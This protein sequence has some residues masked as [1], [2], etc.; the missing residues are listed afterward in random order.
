MADCIRKNKYQFIGICYIFF[1]GY[2]LCS[3]A[4]GLTL[5]KHH[6]KLIT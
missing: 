1:W 2:A 5:K 3:L 4:L 6:E